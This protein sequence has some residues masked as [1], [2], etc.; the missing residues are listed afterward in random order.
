[1][2]MKTKPRS[3]AP[4][5]LAKRATLIIGGTSTADTEWPFGPDFLAPYIAITLDP[6]LAAV[7]AHV[8]EMDHLQPAEGH[9]TKM[10][11]D[12]FSIRERVFVHMRAFEDKGCAVRHT[13]PYGNIT[14]KSTPQLFKDVKFEATSSDA[15]DVFI[16]LPEF[17]M[18]EDSRRELTEAVKKHGEA[19]V[20]EQ[21]CEIFREG[22]TPCPDGSCGRRRDYGGETCRD[23]CRWMIEFFSRHP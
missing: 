1:M 16:T 21:A 19:V 20:C 10:F 9:E 8:L 11:S 5:K 12:V 23:V 13:D 14:F 7:A 17:A 15:N 2:T 6:P 18:H 4:R 22:D 3:L